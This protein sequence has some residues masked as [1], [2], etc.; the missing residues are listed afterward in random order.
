MCSVRLLG[1]ESVVCANY[2]DFW[3]KIKSPNHKSKYYTFLQQSTQSESSY[4]SVVQV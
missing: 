4:I 2:I 3:L 1:V